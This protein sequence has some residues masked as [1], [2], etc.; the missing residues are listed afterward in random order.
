MKVLWLSLRVIGEGDARGS[1]S[2][3]APLAEGLAATGEIELANIAQGP[4]G[5]RERRDAG[6]IRQWVVPRAAPGSDG[7][8][9]APIVDAVLAA[10]HEFGPDLIHVWGVEE[11]WGLLTARRLLGQPALLEIQG[12][13][14][15][16]ARVY[17]GGLTL[18]EQRQCRGVKEIV[19]RRDIAAARRTFAAWGRFEHEMIAGHRFITTQSPWVQAWAEAA[20]PRARFFHTELALRGAFYAAAPWAPSSSTTVFCSAAYSIPSKGVHDAVRAFA[21]LKRRVPEARLRIAGALPE[22]PGRLKDGYNTWLRR[23]AVRLGVEASIDWLG[24]LSAEEVVRELHGCA[25]VLMPSHC[26]SYSVALAEALYLGAPSVCTHSGGP[27]WLARDDESALFFAPGDEVMCAHQLSRLLTDRALATRLSQAAR[28][29][30]AG[31]NDIDGIVAGQAER[32]RS[33]LGASGV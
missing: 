4:V 32:Y 29:A 21:L 26:E 13:K 8:P 5:T 7:T 12:L 17:A 19:R 10:A 28:A 2:W 3:L 22:R 23:L 25:A 15:P 30:A 1:C 18:R 33:V 20:N 9:P 31:R 11:Y 27:D 14:A 24:S 6:A 16:L